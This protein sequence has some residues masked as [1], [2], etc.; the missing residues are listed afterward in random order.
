MLLDVGNAGQCLRNRIDLVIVFHAAEG[1]KLLQKLV[2]SRRLFTK[3]DSA[4]RKE[5]R[6]SRKPCDLVTMKLKVI[7]LVINVLALERLDQTRS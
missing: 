3:M 6:L 2:E 7:G 5:D 4:V 1:E